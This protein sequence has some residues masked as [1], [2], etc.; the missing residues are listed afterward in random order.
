MAASSFRAPW[1]IQR[2]NGSPPTSFTTIRLFTLEV[3]DFLQ[4]ELQRSSPT[5]I[6]LSTFF[7]EDE[8][9]SVETP[10]SP[11]ASS[12]GVPTDQSTLGSL[13]HPGPFCQVLV[14]RQ[15][16]SSDSSYTPD[17][18]GDLPLML[19]SN[20]TSSHSTI[21]LEEYLAFRQQHSSTSANFSGSSL[22]TS[23]SLPSESVHSVDSD[24]TWLSS[25]MVN[26][27]G[28]IQEEHSENSDFSLA[29]SMQSTT[30]PEQPL[31]LPERLVVQ[32]E[33]RG[34]LQFLR[35]NGRGRDPPSVFSGY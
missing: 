33:V 16:P 2:L 25:D 32:S 26:E 30:Q 34:M 10:P 27:R 19:D 15:Y 3:P 12:P 18:C 20:A 8:P 14:D 22:Y 4:Q 6:D 11:N 7:S 9:S 17:S 23:L 13:L 5:Q 24:L 1:Y 31:S 35:D 29:T 28:N 21:S